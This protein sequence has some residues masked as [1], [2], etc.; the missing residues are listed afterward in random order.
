ME[1]K[2]KETKE[3][4]NVKTIQITTVNKFTN[5]DE[6]KA[7]AESNKTQEK[8]LEKIKKLV[9]DLQVLNSKTFINFDG[10]VK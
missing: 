8:I 3:I 2:H 7:L 6:A 5:G 10:N 9:D 4:T 1:N